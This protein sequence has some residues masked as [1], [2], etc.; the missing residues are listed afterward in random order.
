[1]GEPA[2]Q[3]AKEELAMR[4]EQAPICGE[5]HTVKVWRPATFEYE[6]EGITIRVP[7]LYAWVCPT[8]GEASF[9]SDTVDELLLTIRDLLTAAKRARGRRSEVTEYVVSVR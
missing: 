7:N 2:I 5:H 1:M 6:D 4:R 8:G 9:T 3:A